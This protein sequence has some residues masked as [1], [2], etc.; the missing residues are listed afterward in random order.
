MKKA[1]VVLIV[2]CLF[3]GGSYFSGGVCLAFD[4]PVL[5]LAV[6]LEMARIGAGDD[7]LRIT[8]LNLGNLGI[9]SLAGI[10]Q[11]KNLESLDLRG[12]PIKDL[13]PVQGLTKLVSLNLRETAVTDLSPIKN[14]TGL[15]YLNLHSTPAA[16]ISVI[17]GLVNLETLIMRNVKVGDQINAFRG[18]VRL[19]RLN[20]RNTGVTDLTVLGELM[21]QGALQDLQQLGIEAEVDLRDNPLHADPRRDDYATVRPYWDRIAVREP[22]NL[23]SIKEQIVY[24]NEI[25]SSNGG[26]LRDRQGDSSDWIELYNANSYAVDLSGYFLSDDESET[27]KWQFPHGTV[28][29]AKGYLVVFASGKDT[30]GNGEIHTNF[31]INA[32]GEPIILADPAGEMVDF[33]PAVEIARNVAYGRLPDGSWELWYLPLPTPGNRNSSYGSYR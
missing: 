12:N 16:D 23:P 11:L 28:I 18:L 24:I 30:A 20:I 8:S 25:M 5:E 13:T 6:Q 3:A 29:E 31:S 21:E 17:T 27:R 22:Y 33:L 1:A 15:R 14:L 10:E 19:R 2:L 7:L 32:M 9:S 4:D 26:V